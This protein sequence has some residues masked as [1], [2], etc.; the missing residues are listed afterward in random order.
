MPY[1]ANLAIDEEDSLTLDGRVDPQTPAR[2][3]RVAIAVV[4]LPHIS[5]HTDFLALEREPASRGSSE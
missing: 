4:R 1:V 5:N 3:D 2:A